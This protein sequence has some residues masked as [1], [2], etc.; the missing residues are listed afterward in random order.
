MLTDGFDATTKALVRLTDAFD[1]TT[2]ALV[3]LTDVYDVTTKGLVRLTD[4]F[5]VTTKGLVRLTDAFDVTTKR[6]VRQTW[7]KGIAWIEGFHAASL[8][9]ASIW[10]Q[11]EHCRFSLAGAAGRPGNSGC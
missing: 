5:D 10:K 6:L 7:R 4:G 3:R 2:K 11:V 8:C 9:P 1:V